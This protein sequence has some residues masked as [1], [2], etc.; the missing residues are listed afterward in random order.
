MPA[1]LGRLRISTALPLLVLSV[2][3]WSPKTCLQYPRTQCGDHPNQKLGLTL[4]PIERG[5]PEI[6]KNKIALGCPTNDFLGFPR[7]FL[8]PKNPLF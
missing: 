3:R 7:H 8:S 6:H 5:L 1:L 2:S 4:S